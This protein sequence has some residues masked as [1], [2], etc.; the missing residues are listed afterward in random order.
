MRFQEAAFRS[1]PPWQH[2]ETLAGLQ[3]APAETQWWALVRLKV[4][5]GR[6]FPFPELSGV[7]RRYGSC[8]RL[9]SRWEQV[10]QLMHIAKRLS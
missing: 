7:R 10:V 5:E 4:R 1:V 9:F 6:A 8:L 2:P 3:A